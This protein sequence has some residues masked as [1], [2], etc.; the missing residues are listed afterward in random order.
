MSRIGKKPVLIPQG[1][2]V[3]INNDIL[4]ISGKLGNF[5]IKFASSL[6]IKED[7][8]KLYILLKSY[9]KKNSAIY[10]L[11]RAKIN[12]MVIGVSSGFQKML[13]ID[14]VGYKFQLEGVSLKI[15]AGYSH[16]ISINIPKEVKA[17]TESLSKII[18]RSHNLEE[19]GQI[20]SKIRSI[21]PPEPYKGKGIRYENEKIALKAGKTKK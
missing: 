15:Y 18:L 4:K 2:S 17:T 11:T 8:N 21:K 16:V 20:A 12:N 5:E 13:I 10:G 9:S 6:S 7:A 3:S 19:L 14:G 1:V